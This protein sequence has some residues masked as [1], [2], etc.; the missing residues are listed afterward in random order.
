MEPTYTIL[1]SDG[2]KYGPVTAEQLRGWAQDGRIGGDTQVWRSDS[3]AWVAASAL[4][5][6]G[7]AAAT[8]IPAGAPQAP[9]YAAVPANDTD[10]ERRV[11]SG[12]SWFYWIAAISLINSVAILSGQ[13]W[14]L[15]L[16]LGIT[17]EIDH[18]FSEANTG[19]KAIAFGIDAIAAGT[20]ALFGY[21]AGKGHAWSF[22]I[23]GGLLILDMVLTILQ[24]SWL[25]T[26]FHAWAIFSIFL[27][28]KASRAMRA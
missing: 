16:G 25:S 13:G 7:I 19:A 11:K 28:F 21:F 3:A 20:V 5:E 2:K 22:I 17:R 8:T 9:I 27:G 15:A 14:G 1:G 4:P 10:L 24:Q 26:A 18:A 23:G 6:L 12:S